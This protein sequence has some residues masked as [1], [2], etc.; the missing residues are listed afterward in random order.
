MVNQLLDKYTQR[1]QVPIGAYWVP[2]PPQIQRAASA[3]TNVLHPDDGEHVQAKRPPILFIAL[4]ICC[5]V[6]FAFLI[7]R[8]G[9]NRGTKVALVT[10]TK[11]STPTATPLHT[12]TPTPIALEAQDSVIRGGDTSGSVLL[13]PVNLRVIL[14]NE[15]QPRLFVVQRRV[16]KTTEWNYDD[17]PD[18][19]SYIAGLS[20]RPVLGIPWSEENVVLF[21]LMEPE[22]TFVLQMNTGASLRFQFA[23]R[24]VVN[25][26]DTSAFRQVGPGLVLVLI[27]ERNIDTNE[28]TPNRVVVNANYLPEQELASGVLSGIQLPLVDTPTPTLTPTPVQRMDVQIISVETTAERVMIRLRI[29]NGQHRSARIDGQSVWLVYG[30]TERPVGPRVA[31]EIQPFVLEAGQAAD[32][33]ITFAWRGEPFA[34]LGVL[35]DYQ[36]AVNFGGEPHG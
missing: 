6:V 28:I 32:L 13:Y 35:E 4:G 7:L 1:G 30:Y 20:V 14:N 31:A 11:T 24:N 10:G 34:T 8:G 26:A 18:T 16:I 33:R 2:T 36:F 3:N 29:Y 25:R 22:T 9:G 23:S 17:N 19:A 21:D 27:G 5:I 12:L 15:R